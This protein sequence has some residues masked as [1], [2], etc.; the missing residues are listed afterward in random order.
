[1]TRL[2]AAAMFV[3][4]AATPALACELNQSAAAGSV[5][6]RV[7]SAAEQA[8]ASAPLLVDR[9]P[10][11]TFNR[12]L[13]GRGC[14]QR[15]GTATGCDWNESQVWPACPFC[16]AAI[17]GAFCTGACAT[18]PGSS[19]KKVLGAVPPSPSL[20]MAG[21]ILAKLNAAMAARSMIFMVSL[22]SSGLASKAGPLFASR[23]AALCDAQEMGFQAARDNRSSW[24]RIY[25]PPTVQKL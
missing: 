6:C 23:A 2:I 17:D 7:T 20:A 14:S 11:P 5:H 13:A 4:A 9:A 19:V 15:T 21:Q 12:A 8:R 24:H 16:A 18:T 22:H 10:E 1:M 3:V 25:A